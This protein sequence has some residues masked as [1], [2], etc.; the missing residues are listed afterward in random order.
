MVNDGHLLASN[1]ELWETIDNNQDIFTADTG[2]PGP[3]LVVTTKTSWCLWLENIPFRYAHLYT[4]IEYDNETLELDGVK[5]V[6][7]DSWYLYW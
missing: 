4:M 6:I 1:A 5:S 2:M 3:R 7:V